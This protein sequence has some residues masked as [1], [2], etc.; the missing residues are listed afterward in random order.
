MKNIFKQWL[1][2]LWIVILPACNNAV[3][4]LYG[5]GD[6]KF[7]DD[8]EIAAL[9]KKYSMLLFW[10]QY[11]GRQTGRYLN[12]LHNYIIKNKVKDISDIYYVNNDNFL[13]AIEHNR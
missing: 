3:S 11:L 4:R 9:A 1:I 8:N 10:N 13:Y 7:L 12:E 2:L 5:I 6:S